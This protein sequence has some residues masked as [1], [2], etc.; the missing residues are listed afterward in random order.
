VPLRGDAL[1]PFNNQRWLTEAVGHGHR[2]R[3]IKLQKRVGLSTNNT[4]A[5][6]LIKKSL[7]TWPPYDR[8]YR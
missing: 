7:T 8:I 2:G 5:P 4:K 3:A 6:T 1:H